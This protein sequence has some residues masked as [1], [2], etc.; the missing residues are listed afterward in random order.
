MEIRLARIDDLDSITAIYYE[1]IKT[2]TATFDI[3]PRL[4]DE[5]EKWFE[6]HTDPRYPL[7]V[8]DINEVVVGWVSLS[9]WSKRDAFKD[10]AEISFYV[11]TDHQDRG[12]GTALVRAIISAARSI[13]LHALIAQITEGSEA[14]LHINRS[15]GFRH[16][17]LL[18]EVG[19]KFGKTLDVC[20][21]ELLL[22]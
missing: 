9:P 16:A 14:S 17:G 8:A 19:K 15:L 6:E 21:Y 3:H 7:Y 10:T 12:I 13:G 18:R 22:D 11:N 5:Q 4:S 1:A 20:L 2:T